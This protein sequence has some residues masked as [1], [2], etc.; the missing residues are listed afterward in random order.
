M[1]TDSKE[2]DLNLNRIENAIYVYNNLLH[3]GIKNGPALHSDGFKSR[4]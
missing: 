1:V 2:N 4:D 3:M